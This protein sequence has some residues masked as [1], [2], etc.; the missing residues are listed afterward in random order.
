M[1]WQ[2][3]RK[4]R[5][6]TTFGFPSAQCNEGILAIYGAASEEFIAHRRIPNAGNVFRDCR[7]VQPF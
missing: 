7:H 4:T 5:Q 1:C 3:R 2:S 6:C